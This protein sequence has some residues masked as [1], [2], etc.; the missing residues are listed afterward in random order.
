MNL[1]I[2]L[3]KAVEKIRYIIIF[4]H[5]SDIIHTHLTYQRKL[6]PRILSHRKYLKTYIKYKEAMLKT[7]FDILTNILL[8]CLT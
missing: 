6:F 2:E 5:I 4:I 7:G 3:M 8:K 1:Q